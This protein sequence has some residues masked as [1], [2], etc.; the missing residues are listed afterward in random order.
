MGNPGIFLIQPNG[1]L[2]EMNEQFPEN[3]MYSSAKLSS[4][5]DDKTLA[6]FLDVIRWSVEEVRAAI[7]RQR[8]TAT[9]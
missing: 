1:D 8:T 5:A 7:G 6:A 9:S 3:P 4:L 2:V